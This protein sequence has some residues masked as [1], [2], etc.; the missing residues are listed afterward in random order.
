MQRA[1]GVSGVMKGKEQTIETSG[2]CR[3]EVQGGD[4]SAFSGDDSLVH[5]HG[6]RFVSKVVNVE[7][8]TRAAGQRKSNI[9]KA[10]AE[11]HSLSDA[12]QRPEI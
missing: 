6:L 11:P 10:Q 12:F 9:V 3:L 5:P 7:S 2:A 1:R 8:R 4:T